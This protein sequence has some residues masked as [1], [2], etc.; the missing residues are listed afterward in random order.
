VIDLDN[1][2]GYFCEA[3]CEKLSVMGSEPPPAGRES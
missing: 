2:E 3:I 1:N